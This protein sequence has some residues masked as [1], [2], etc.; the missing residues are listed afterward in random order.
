MEYAKTHGFTHGANFQYNS[1]YP[2]DGNWPWLISVGDNVTLA[3]GV[4]L[5]AY[6]ASTAKPAKFICSFDD[7]QNKHQENQKNI[8]Y[9][10][11]I[12]GRN[13]LTLVTRNEY[14]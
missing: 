14:R 10:A 9:S 8:R 4:K 5:L 12:H 6:D 3:S 2:I 1:G 7:Y 13:G 11:S